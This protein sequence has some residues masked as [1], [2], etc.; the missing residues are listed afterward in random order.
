MTLLG[1][2][3]LLLQVQLPADSGLAHAS[4]RPAPV[5]QATFASEA[6]RLDGRLDEAVWRQAIPVTDFRRDLPSDGG[7]A[8]EHT[9][10][11]VV[12]TR[13][14]LYVG[15]RLNARDPGTV[16]RLRG[17]RDSFSL[18][19]DQFLVMVDSHHDH[20]TAYV[21][22]VTPAGGR[23]DLLVPDDSRDGLDP[24]WDP[25]WEAETRVDE[26][27]WVAEI[28]IPFTQLRFSEEA[29]RPVWGIQ[30]RRD[31]VAAGEAADWSWAPASEAGFVS[32]FGH[33]VGLE[34]LEAP[35]R[36][37]ILP[38][39]VGRGS[40]DQRADPDS[41]FDDG[42]VFGTSVGVDLK[43][44]LTPALTLD[45]TVNPDFGQVEADPA[46]VNLSAFE[47]FFEERRPFFVEGAG[48]FEF[49]GL[50]SMKF[51]YSRRVGQSPSLPASGRYVDRP[52][53]STI[54]GAAKL[55][56][57]TAGGW[58]VGALNA[59]TDRE[60]ARIT[61]SPDGPVVTV[62][63]EPRANY[64][65]L[66]LR[67]DFNESAS[68]VGVIATSVFRERGDPAF[69][70]LRDRAFTG[71]VDFAHRWAR[72]AYVVR[73]WVGGSRVLGSTAAITRAQRA[74]ARYYQ[75]PDQAY[76]TLDPT[77]TALS[78]FGA[79][80]E[81]QKLAGAWL[82]GLNGQS[83]S[84]GF[85]LNDAGF[86]TQ[87]DRHVALVSGRRR[88]VQ[89]TAWFRSFSMGL[90]GV[91]QW[92]FGG[93]RTSSNLRF[94]LVGQTHAFRSFDV[95]LRH[96]LEAFDTRATRGG[97]RVVRPRLWGLGAGM[98]TDDRK[99]LSG[100]ARVNLTSGAE[101]SWSMAITPSLAGRGQGWW[102]WSATA[103][104]RRS[105]DDAFYV[106]QGVDSAAATTFGSR[107]VFAN[108]ARESVDVTLRLD[109]ALTPDL[110]LQLYAQPF[111]A[112]GAYTDFR[113]LA[114]PSSYDF[115]R[116]GDG[117]S[118]VSSDPGTG[119]V[120][121][122][123]DGAGPAATVSFAD[124]DFR[125]RSLRGNLVL[126]W[127]YRPGSTLFFVWSQNRSDRVTD[128]ELE[129]WGDLSHT[130][131]DPGQHVFLIKANYWLGS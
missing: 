42:S 89:P 19:N 107:Y 9:E 108:L 72:R 27:G 7:P 25:V 125:L 34:R 49:G 67:R 131:R 81:L 94:D 16:S 39:T 50:S 87:A 23:N 31:I 52:A 123:A 104:Y 40:F 106:A 75:R 17:R 26:K 95:N 73:G 117:A 33:L 32:K 112:S 120:R 68:E 130:W 22:G 47:T 90:L 115:L 85:E 18:F 70:V 8:S 11:R 80:V 124:P 71:G 2:A 13:D 116:Y 37:E 58:T 51:F 24:S 4:G 88:W 6:P 59:T 100:S 53:A 122:D 61:D 1:T 92:D 77:A 35:N 83:L 74:S 82:F 44:G 56:G 102:N 30:F 118:T 97:P 55:S 129:P 38:Y 29:E 99:P 69:E 113:A 28:R 86:Q 65:V 78:G 128:A 114:R 41:P 12:Y 79:E 84:P 91:S 66:R 48:G 110:T 111:V 20:R 45:A 64:S 105:E 126:R 3:L 127:E 63:V 109:L 98:H 96:E 103:A 10:V 54:L 60:R 119:R 43:Y 62:P 14:A 101:G 93:T 36:L 46:V 121:V 76:V 5:V 15:A 21:F 57:R